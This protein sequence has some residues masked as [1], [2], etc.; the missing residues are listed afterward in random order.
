MQPQPTKGP[1][2]E[3]KVL[4]D[5]E[6]IKLP[7]SKNSKS[8][9]NIHFL[10]QPVSKRNISYLNQDLVLKE[11]FSKE[12]ISPIDEDFKQLTEKQILKNL[13]VHLNNGSKR[14]EIQNLTVITDLSNVPTN[15][16]FIYKPNNKKPKVIFERPTRPPKEIKTTISTTTSKPLTKQTTSRPITTTTRNLPKATKA[17][18]K[19]TTKHSKSS[20]DFSSNIL[21]AQKNNARTNS[22][23]NSTSI[24]NFTRN[25]TTNLTANLTKQ[26]NFATDR[27]N[28]TVTK[29]VQHNNISKSITVVTKK[30][31]SRER[32]RQLTMSRIVDCGFKL[33]TLRH[34]YSERCILY[35]PTNSSS[36]RI[37]CD[38]SGCKHEITHGMCPIWTCEA[39]DNS[40]T[41]YVPIEP[42]EPT[43]TPM[44]FWCSNVSFY[45]LLAFFVVLFIGL[46]VQ[47]GFT[48]FFRRRM[49]QYRR[50]LLFDP[51]RRDR[52]HDYDE[53]SQ[54]MMLN[55]SSNLPSYQSLAMGRDQQ[56]ENIRLDYMDE[57]NLADDEPSTSSIIRQRHQIN[58]QGL[59]NP[60]FSLSSSPEEESC[61]INP[62]LE[63]PTAPSMSTFRN[64]RLRSAENPYRETT[65]PIQKK[66]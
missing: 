14:H 62:V 6:V 27:I 55:Q 20:I 8:S 48:Y 30:F 29:L 26:S 33:C 35:L 11:H 57:I 50:A 19:S 21:I 61:F 39:K 13:D 3:S 34:I 18:K 59:V 16:P 65:S 56:R 60:L 58:Q 45:V 38:L 22:E 37:P 66:P 25:V 15:T 23:T 49:H 41:P 51:P 47:G 24:L 43:P 32:Q 28:S 42:T 31:Q 2:V 52:L 4:D 46:F 53:E 63:V 44:P 7:L 1:F 17:L 9:L 64:Q 54:P 36:C 5:K 10:E 12:N 40:T